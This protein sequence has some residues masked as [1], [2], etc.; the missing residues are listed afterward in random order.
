SV[1]GDEEPSSEFPPEFFGARARADFF[2][3]YR[4]LERKAE[5]GIEGSWL[6]EGAVTPRQTFIRSLL[7]AGSAPVPCILRKRASPFHINLSFQGLG[8]TVI[9]SLAEVLTELPTIE[10]LNVRDNRLTDASLVDLIN[11]VMRCPSITELDLSSNK[12]DE[13]AVSLREYV[14]S[15]GCA[16]KKLC[17]SQADV[18]DDECHEMMDALVTNSSITSLDISHNQIG[19]KETL[20][21]VVPGYTTGGEATA[22]MLCRNYVLVHL[23]LSWNH[24]RQDSAVEIGKVIV[25]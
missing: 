5:D 4:L 9:K 17:L 3:S 18:D 15:P 11:A 23:D 20:N 24:I 13:A 8:D 14:A 7:R 12:V 10:V 2:R 16:L 1:S 25:M 6:E 19:T 21:F 22:V